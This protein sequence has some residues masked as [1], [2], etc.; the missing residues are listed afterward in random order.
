MVEQHIQAR[1]SDYVYCESLLRRDDKDRWLASLF[2]PAKFRPHVQAIYALSVETARIHEAVTEPLLGEIRIQWWRDVIEGINPGDA[3][4]SPVAAALLDTI[5]RF[6]LPKTPL[7]EL[8]EARL[9]RDIYGDALESVTALESYAEATGANL[10]RLA[11]LIL[12]RSDSFADHGTTGH[13][14]IAYRIV[15][16]LRALP[17]HCARGQVFV[18]DEILAKRGIGRAQFLAGQSSPEAIGALADLRALTRRHLD[19]FIAQL[20]G[21]VDKVRPALLPVSLCEP[22]LQ[23]MENLLYDPFKTT[24][25][26]PQWRRQWILWRASRNWS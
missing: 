21:V 19:I 11:M 13:A 4:A 23:Q 25:E 20:P 5:A 8:L 2:I 1:K 16:L 7:L 14:G 26:L 6:D 12:D 10:F 3:K 22:Y 18:P 17:W 9:L 24:V 15:G